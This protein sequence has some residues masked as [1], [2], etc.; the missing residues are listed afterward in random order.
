MYYNSSVY[1][2]ATTFGVV[3]I[4]FIIIIWFILLGAISSYAKRLG[5]DEIGWVIF[6]IFCTP[7][8]GAFA[9]WLKG[10]TDEHRKNRIIEEENWKESCKG[11][12]NKESIPI[13]AIKELTEEEKIV[14]E[15]N[16]KQN[17]KLTI[18]IAIAFAVVIIISIIIVICSQK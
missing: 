14:I 7:L 5:R 17:S 4:I 11:S 15:E 12:L 16:K 2:A 10:E 18:A 9:L 13:E 1:Q 3:S 6:S 8:A